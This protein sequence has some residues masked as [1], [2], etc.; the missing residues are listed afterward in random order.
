MGGENCYMSS[1][2]FIQAM[3]FLVTVYL[4]KKAEASYTSCLFLLFCQ[5]FYSYLIFFS[6]LLGFPKRAFKSQ[7]GYCSVGTSQKHMNSEVMNENSEESG[8]SKNKQ[9]CYLC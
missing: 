6:L 2:L 3:N 8:G 1:I 9:F 5:L 4:G 7:K